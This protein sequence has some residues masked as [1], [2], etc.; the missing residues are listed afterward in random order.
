MAAILGRTD[1]A[2]LLKAE[3]LAKRFGGI[4]ALTGYH[5]ALEAGVLAG[6]IGPNGAGKTTVFNLLTGVIR[7]TEG[8]IVFAGE[9]ITGLRAD[10]FTERG[11]AR[12]FQNSRL[13]RDLT[14]LE[15][16]AAALN[17]RHGAGL[18][19]TVA[20]LPRAAASERAIAERARELLGLFGLEGM[21]DTRSADLPYGDQRRVEIA[22]ALATEPKLLLLD[23]P[24]AGL[25]PTE[26]ADLAAT[27]RR[28]HDRFGLTTIVVE[29]DMSLVMGLCERVQVID[30]GEVLAFDRPAAVQSDPR[31]VEA[32]LARA[33][34]RDGVA[35]ML[36]AAGL[37]VWRGPTR[38]LDAVDLTVQA[39]EIVALIGSNGAG[40][41]S[42]L[43][44]ISGLL[45]PRAGTLTL[46][47]DQGARVPLNTVAPETDRRPGNR[48]VPRGPPG[49]RLAVR[50]GKL[51]GRGLSA[52]R[53]RDDP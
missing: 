11:I 31:V 41:T 43:M 49:L 17:L 29:H 23:E 9:D 25:N 20:G 44:T 32:Y 53:P 33:G 24:A 5:I 26:T 40:K 22:R 13:F 8:R 50:A 52:A 15:N 4:V 19:A 16:V 14:V 18:L 45:R 34:A 21:A 46:T 3:G 48:P 2:P 47:D 6:L 10:R 30:R 1:P 28:I 27:I 7:P 38:V 12:T 39:G 37:E 51:A 35:A 42:T 36:E